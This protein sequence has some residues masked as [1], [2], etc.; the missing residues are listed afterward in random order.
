MNSEG[1]S[2]EDA[3][4][5]L[6]VAE[7]G[8]FSAAAKALG[9]GQPT[10][11]RR[12]QHL[13]NVLEQQLFER[14]K[15]GAKPTS[16]AVKLLPAAEQM[17][18]WA[19]E[20]NRQASGI[21]AAVSGIVKIAAAPGVAVE[22]LAP[23]ASKLKIDE[24]SIILEVLSSIEHVDLTRGGADIAIRTKFPREPELVVVFKSVVQPVVVGSKD[25]VESLNQPC[26]WEDIA[27]VS[28]ASPYKTV[29][30]R[31]MLEKIIDNFSPV[32]TSDDYLVQQ[33]AVRSGLGAFI[34]NRRVGFETTDLVEIDMGI[35]LPKSEFYVVC[36]KSMQQVPRVRVVIEHLASALGG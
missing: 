34:T 32:F 22:Q 35:V 14:G 25:Y 31:P 18:K 36:A 1:V 15:Y 5:F 17:A 19:G 29:S 33:A 10:I 8:S 2:W 6:S 12:I 4:L 7:H 27:W 26:R 21:G 23:F 24:P 3:Q 16:A 30:P 9:I 20:F 13:E 28:W 11:S